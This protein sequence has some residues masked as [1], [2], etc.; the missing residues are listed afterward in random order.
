MPSAPPCSRP[1]EPAA[2]RPRPSGCTAGSTANAHPHT[3]SGHG[4][5]LAYEGIP[6]VTDQ[7]R[8]SIYAILVALTAL[9]VAYGLMTQD[10]AALWV[11]LIKTVIDAAALLLA[12]RNVPS[13]IAK[14]SADA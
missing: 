12:R 14:R 4:G 10:M 1:C 2:L 3:P 6:A 7:I 8:A 9:I 11:A 13:V 5:C